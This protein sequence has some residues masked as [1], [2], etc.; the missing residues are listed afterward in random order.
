MRVDGKFMVGSDI[1]EGQ[2][3]VN[4]LLAECY[5]MA[6]NLR[7]QAS[8]EEESDQEEE[9][10]DPEDNARPEGNDYQEK[11]EHQQ[12]GGH[13]DE[14]KHSLGNGQSEESMTSKANRAPEVN[15][16]ASA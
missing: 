2:G 14:N 13:P 1:P 9:D 3:G 11:D 10:D 15:G 8:Q 7:A 6:Y 16:L 4:A 5:E 12:R